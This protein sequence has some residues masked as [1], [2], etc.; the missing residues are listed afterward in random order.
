MRVVRVVKGR[1]TK[2]FSCE[3]YE[4]TAGIHIDRG[5]GIHFAITP[6]PWVSYSDYPPVMLGG[7]HTRFNGTSCSFPTAQ[8]P[9]YKNE[10]ELEAAMRSWAQDPEKFF[11]DIP[12][13]T[14][15]PADEFERLATPR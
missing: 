13:A 1:R 2:P 12:A 4:F 7:G 6:G 10:E 5:D 9:F 15:I 8:L 14:A 3:S 11:A